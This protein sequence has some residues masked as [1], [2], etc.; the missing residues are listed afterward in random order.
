[1]VENPNSAYFLSNLFFSLF[2]F[3]FS[4]Y[5][6]ERALKRA[7]ISGIKGRCCQSELRATGQQFGVQQSDENFFAAF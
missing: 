1:M 6:K 3:S 4:D 7:T 2:S 5:I